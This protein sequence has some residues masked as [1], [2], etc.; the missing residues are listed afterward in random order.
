MSLSAV[1]SYHLALEGVEAR[2]PLSTTVMV[3]WSRDAQAGA[4]AGTQAAIRRKALQHC[5]LV[6]RYDEERATGTL[7]L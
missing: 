2:N 5:W 1:S 7:S 6:A 4:A 3:D